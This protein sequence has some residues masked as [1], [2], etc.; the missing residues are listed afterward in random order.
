MQ[1]TK[2]LTMWDL[3]KLMVVLNQYKN[4]RMDLT[5]TCVSFVGYVTRNGERG[6]WTSDGAW[7][8]CRPW[9]RDLRLARSVK[10]S[11]HASKPSLVVSNLGFMARTMLS[12]CPSA[13]RQSTF[14]GILV[15]DR[16]GLAAASSLPCHPWRG[17]FRLARSAESCHASKPYLVISNLGFMAGTSALSATRQSSFG[18]TLFKRQEST[19]SLVPQNGA[20]L[21]G[22]P[23]F[24]RLWH[25]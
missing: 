10:S 24:L 17:D 18:G 22:L 5:T 4:K 19:T 11:W 25:R 23:P 3:T 20:Q 21:N 12:A 15:G 13:I 16:Y 14:E 8:L 2:H 9:H 7:P 6:R 1:G